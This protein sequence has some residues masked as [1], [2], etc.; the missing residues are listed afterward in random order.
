[1][2]WEET[3]SLVTVQNGN[4]QHNPAWQSSEHTK[5][6]FIDGA[7]KKEDIYT[8]QGWFC[9]TVD[10]IEVMMG[11]MNLRRSLSSLHEE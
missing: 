4:L 6:C 3:Q 5:I 1:M 2:L 10:S 9:R 11:T 7:W 8:G